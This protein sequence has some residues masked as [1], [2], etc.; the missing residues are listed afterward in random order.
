MSL[1]SS[2]PGGIFDVC[3]ILI[4]NCL[5]LISLWPHH[6]CHLP[7]GLQSICSSPRHLQCCLQVVWPLSLWPPCLCWVPFNLSY[8]QPSELDGLHCLG[9]SVRSHYWRYVTTLLMTLTDELSMISIATICGDLTEGRQAMQNKRRDKASLSECCTWFWLVQ[10]AFNW[11][12]ESSFTDK[13][14]LC[15]SNVLFEA[16]HVCCI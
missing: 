3:H 11:S 4:D 1:A 7:L 2:W 8:W 5:S 16:L 15:L 10:L 12:L 6:G 13:G 9:R 14:S